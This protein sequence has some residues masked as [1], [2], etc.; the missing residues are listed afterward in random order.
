MY[1]DRNEE[2]RLEAVQIFLSL[3]YNK[4]KEFQ[5]IVDL[6]CELCNTPVALIT[7]L[8]KD[9]N[10]L[11]VKSGLNVDFM[12]RE[13]SFCQYGIQQDNIMIVRNAKQDSRFDNNPL[14]QEP[15]NVLFYAGVPLIINNGLRLGM[16]C[17]FDNK[18]ND[19]SPL[20]QKTLAILSRQ[21]TYLMELELSHML[22][23]AKM[24]EIEEQNTSLRK[25]AHMQ[26]HDIRQPLT[27]IMGLI[28]IIKEDNYLYDK[29][30]ILMMEEAACMLDSKIHAIV[31]QTD[32][33]NLL[34]AA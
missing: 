30:R 16:L 26:S 14:V 1:S 21:V 4:S 24:T 12:P 29:E 31:Q 8:D 18:P 5:E 10:W 15:P 32:T 28:N 25:I 19:L 22:L 27:S 3:D 9:I 34:K 13:T 6:A 7:L 17:L 2:A 11:K 20:Q 33:H 23:Q